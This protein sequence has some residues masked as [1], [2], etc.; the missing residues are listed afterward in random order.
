M[1]TNFSDKRFGEPAW[2]WMC[3]VAAAEFSVFQN[4]SFFNSYRK[5]N[6]L[7]CIVSL[8]VVIFQNCNPM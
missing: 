2:I 1:M 6:A 7:F 4:A 3:I 8:F 5:K